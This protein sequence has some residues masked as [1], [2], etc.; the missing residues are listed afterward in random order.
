[1]ST[2]LQLVGALLV[3]L[4]FVFSQLGSLGTSTPTYLWPNLIG[5][6]LLAVLA[7]KGSQW[8]FVLLEGV[9]AFASLRSLLTRG[10]EPAAD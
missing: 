6:L 1:V 2:V 10:P 5:S 7:V 9:W 8:G 3:L 4:P